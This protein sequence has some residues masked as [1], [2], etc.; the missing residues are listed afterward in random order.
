MTC[1]I[2]CIPS[3]SSKSSI[4][5]SSAGRFKVKGGGNVLPIGLALDGQNDFYFAV[6]CV[7]WFK[8]I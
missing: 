6:M 4:I 8:C 3:M 1:I 5:W 7:Q 2:I